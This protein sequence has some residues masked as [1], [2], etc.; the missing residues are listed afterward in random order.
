MVTFKIIKF[1][2]PFTGNFTL[3]PYLFLS[4]DTKFAIMKNLLLVI[5][6]IG[7]QFSFKPKGITWVSI[8]DSITYLNEHQ[9]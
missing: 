1:Y 9:D 4:Y 8:G 6:F 5:A 7:I 3:N 2:A